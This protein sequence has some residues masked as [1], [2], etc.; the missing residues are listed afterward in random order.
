[1]EETYLRR[2]GKARS[3]QWAGSHTSRRRDRP[4][5]GCRYL[6]VPADRLRTETGDLAGESGE[7]ARG[8]RATT[9]ATGINNM[10]RPQADPLGVV[11]PNPCHSRAVPR[12]G[13]RLQVQRWLPRPAQ[14]QEGGNPHLE[15][16]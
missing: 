3:H 12:G 5:G 7:L 8:P 13:S 16:G 11:F 2:Q 1:M 4:P 14:C 10:R 9:A 6:L 15:P